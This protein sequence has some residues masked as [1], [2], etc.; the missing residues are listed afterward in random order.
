MGVLSPSQGFW[1]FLIYIRPRYKETSKRHRDKS[2]LRKLYITIFHKPPGN[3]RHNHRSNMARTRSDRPGMTSLV[4]SWMSRTEPRVVVSS[5]Q[6]PTTIPTPERMTVEQTLEAPVESTGR[7]PLQM[8]VIDEEEGRPQ[9]NNEQSLNE[10]VHAPPEQEFMSVGEFEEY[11]KKITLSLLLAEDVLPPRP[12]NISRRTQRRRSMIEFPV[13]TAG[14]GDDNDND[15]DDN[16]NLVLSLPKNNDPSL[17]VET[18]KVITSSNQILNERVGKVARRYSCP[19]LDIAED[20]DLERDL[21]NE[22]DQ[23]PDGNSTGG[24]EPLL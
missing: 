5:N 24:A 19:H 1:N 14:F 16:E 23:K 9:S 7:I 18:K 11:R 22:D 3:N 12:T 15:E 4:R 13:A 21:L 20:L 17:E 8:E 2:F 6:A 10:E